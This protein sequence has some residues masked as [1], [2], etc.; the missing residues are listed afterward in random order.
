M[1]WSR[2]N[3]FNVTSSDV[4]GAFQGSDRAVFY[5]QTDHVAARN[6]MRRRA[7]SRPGIVI[8]S[9]RPRA[10]ALRRL[11]RGGAGP[12]FWG[13]RS[14]GTS[15]IGLGGCMREPATSGALPHTV[16][17]GDETVR[18]VLPG[19][20]RHVA[21]VRLRP[22]PPWVAVCPRAAAWQRLAQRPCA[23]GVAVVAP[24]TRGCAGPLAIPT[25]TIGATLPERA[26]CKTPRRRSL[27]HTHP[28]VACNTW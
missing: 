11:S 6:I 23:S 16:P 19:H 14:G 9:K 13:G 15:S 10:A 17:N 7:A 28:A 1:N 2:C 21:A 22:A 4:A 8:Y 27:E 12:A 3:E 25:Q 20:G 26:R 5:R 24:R 18:R